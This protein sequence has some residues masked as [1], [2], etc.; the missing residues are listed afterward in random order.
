[1]EGATSRQAP[2]P[3]QS[4][5]VPADQPKFHPYLL[6]QLYCVTCTPLGILCPNELPGSQDWEEDSKEEEGNDQGKEED[7]ISVCSD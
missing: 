1:M 2:A 4:A 3:T 5:D 7:N 6:R